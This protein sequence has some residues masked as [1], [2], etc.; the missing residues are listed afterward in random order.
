MERSV[1]AEWLDQLPAE[2]AAARWSRRDLRVLNCWMG[3]AGIMARTLNSIAA[4]EQ[5]GRVVELGAGDGRF[6]LQVVRRLSRSCRTL[7]IPKSPIGPMNLRSIAGA[8]SPTCRRR[9][10]LPLWERAGVRGRSSLDA[11]KG[12]MAVLVD[13]RKAVTGNTQAAF[14][15]LGW[16]VEI[17]QADVFDWLEHTGENAGDVVIANLF[18]HH[19]DDAHLA[20]LL[21]GI[22]RHAQVFVALEPRRSLWS[23]GFSRLVGM[24]GC[25]HVTRHDAPASVRGGFRDH[26]MSELWPAGADWALEEKPAGPFSHLLIARR[27]RRFPKGWKPQK[28]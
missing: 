19:F 8:T 14:A 12:A 13:Q 2:H 25:N 24:L 26:D 27:K 23:L 6:M 11:S 10:S 18:A 9:F 21:R 17:I 5:V 1:E 28:K 4:G 20:A 16:E 7:T 3:N 15:A 22:A